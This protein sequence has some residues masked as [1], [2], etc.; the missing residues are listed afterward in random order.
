MTWSGL[1]CCRSSTLGC[2][3][4]IC[5]FWSTSSMFPLISPTDSAF[6]TSSSTCRTA[7]V[8]Q[9]TAPG[10]VAGFVVCSNQP[11]SRR[12][13]HSEQSQ[14]RWAVCDWQGEWRSSVGNTNMSKHWSLSSY[15]PQRMLLT[16]ITQSSW[17][18]C[19]SLASCAARS[20]YDWQEKVFNQL[21]SC[22]KVFIQC[23]YFSYNPLKWLPEGPF[24]DFGC[25]FT[26]F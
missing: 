25:F 14:W 1:T 5:T 7:A 24:F 4:V 15:R 12:F 26:Y 9:E 19:I 20:G 18:F 21:I 3:Q 11:R 6:I 2:T 10:S 22:T 13:Q 16:S 23:Q 8:K 17:I